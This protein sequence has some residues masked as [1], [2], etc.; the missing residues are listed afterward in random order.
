LIGLL[1]RYNRGVDRVRFGFQIQV[2]VGQQASANT[3]STIA[4]IAHDGKKDGMICFVCQQR[5]VSL[6]A[7]EASARFVL[8]GLVAQLSTEGDCL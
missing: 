6:A 8:A 1:V 2:I 3:V 5:D 4:L 7:N